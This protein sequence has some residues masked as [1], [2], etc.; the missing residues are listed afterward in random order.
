MLFSL[1]SLFLLIWLEKNTSTYSNQNVDQLQSE[2][3]KHMEHIL[4]FC[5]AEVMPAQKIPTL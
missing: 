1:F 3:S 2:F 5:A 4:V